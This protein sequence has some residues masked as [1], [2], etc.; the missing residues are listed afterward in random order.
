MEK[1]TREELFALVW[2]AAQTEVARELGLSDV[3][4]GKL[5]RRLQV[6]KPPRGYSAR[7]RA[8]AATASRRSGRS[9]QPLPPRPGV[10][11]LSRR[12]R[13]WLGEALADLAAAGV[14]A[15]GMPV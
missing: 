11:R 12:R 6:P 13:E 3:G 9:S 14:D 5:C 8:E 2:G 10:T 7:A 1:V 4:L 15:T